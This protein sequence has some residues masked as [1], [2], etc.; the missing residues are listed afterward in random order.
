MAPFRPKQMMQTSSSLSGS[1][2]SRLFGLSYTQ[3][4]SCA[5]ANGYSKVQIMSIHVMVLLIAQKKVNNCSW[6]FILCTSSR[7][8]IYLQCTA[9]HCTVPESV[10]HSQFGGEIDAN[11][12]CPLVSTL[13]APH[14]SRGNIAQDTHARQTADTYRIIEIIDISVFSDGITL[15]YITIAVVIIELSKGNSRTRPRVRR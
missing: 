6:E 3:H 15:H 5:V 9:I 12:M 13:V 7:I 14:K 4:K 8:H 1:K 10:A 11:W 2:A